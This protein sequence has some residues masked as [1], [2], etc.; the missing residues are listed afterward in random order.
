MRKREES[1]ISGFDDGSGGMESQEEERIWELGGL[2]VLKAS[3][4]ILL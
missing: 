3:R 4:F 1:T 2:D